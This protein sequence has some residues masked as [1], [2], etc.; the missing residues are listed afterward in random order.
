MGRRGKTQTLAAG[1]LD[2]PEA[3]AGEPIPETMMVDRIFD[4][5]DTDGSGMLTFEEIRLLAERTG[6]VAITCEEYLGISRAAGFD[7]VAGVDRASLHRIYGELG[8][9]VAA[10]DFA[11]VTGHGPGGGACSADL[12]LD[13][14]L[15]GN[16]VAAGR[17]VGGET[18]TEEEE[19]DEDLEGEEL[20]VLPAQLER[21]GSM[22]STGTGRPTLLCLCAGAGAV[23][24][25]LAALL[26][27][28]GNYPSVLSVA[29]SGN[30]Q[31]AIA[32]GLFFCGVLIAVPPA[33][34]ALFVVTRQPHGHLAQL[35]AGSTHV[36][37]A[38]VATLARSARF[39]RGLVVLILFLAAA[40]DCLVAVR[41][42]WL[43]P[44]TD[45][46]YAV[47]AWPTLFVWWYSLKV[48]AIITAARVASADRQARAVAKRLPDTGGR[49]DPKKW[50]SEVEEPV[51]QLV[52]N[53]LPTLSG[54]WGR[55]LGL[56]MVGLVMIALSI[57]LF[58]RD[59]FTADVS[60]WVQALFGGIIAAFG[61][62]P[63]LLAVDPASASSKCARLED[64]I[65]HISGEDT[66]F[67]PAENFIKYIKR[68]NK[69]QG[70]G[71]LAF[72]ML[73]R[74]CQCWCC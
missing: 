32:Q 66:A 52:R 11:K 37:R 54:G 67:M 46:L 6:G 19:G 72:T 61:L 17:A 24:R 43:G 29:A 65:N 64:S 20:V 70:L 38:G 53:T 2:T 25:P 14:G 51:R 56:I 27:G 23:A 33:L 44:L 5:L 34:H 39:L 22:L 1:L 63:F 48:A 28:I 35:G 40:F 60:L 74:M 18:P 47:I 59:F 55:S 57:F 71:M 69:D 8:M 9:G 36:P 16:P 49:L 42:Y 45:W 62:L 21:V 26:V 7:A 12:D 68:L 4:A 41:G 31:S 50:R 3:A 58:L 13:H 15:V 30:T 10:E 73:F